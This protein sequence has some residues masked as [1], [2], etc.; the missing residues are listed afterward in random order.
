MINTGIHDYPPKVFFEVSAKPCFLQLLK[1]FNKSVLNNVFSPGSII[2]IAM[3]NVASKRIVPPVQTFL[4][5]R[6]T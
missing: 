3:S 2:R 5:G 4:C 1:E 6:L